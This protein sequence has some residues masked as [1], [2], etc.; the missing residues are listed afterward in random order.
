MKAALLRTKED[1][2]HAVCHP[3]SYFL[4]TFAF[5]YCS[6]K[7]A[8]YSAEMRKARQTSSAEVIL[9]ELKRHG[10][11]LAVAALALGHRGLPFR[12]RLGPAQDFRRSRLARPRRPLDAG[13]PR[14]LLH[15]TAPGRLEHYVPADGRRRALSG[16]GLQGRRD[17][18][19]R[20]VG[21]RPTT[22][23]V[24]RK[25]HDRHRPHHGLAL[26]QATPARRCAAAFLSANAS[27]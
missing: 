3:P 8:R 9:G 23:A 20:L 6:P 13:R 26:R 14:A 4:F 24:A 27:G 16:D 18:L 19:F 7:R 5:F 21:G 12:G 25:R 17:R 11:G 1:E 15:Q 10:R 22:R 2:S